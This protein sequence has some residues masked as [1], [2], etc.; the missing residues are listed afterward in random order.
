MCIVYLINN[1][2]QYFVDGMWEAW[3][4]DKETSK[5][6]VENSSNPFDEKWRQE[7]RILYPRY[8]SD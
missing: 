8:L 1:T 7:Y 5:L 4:A 2:A 6:V 3:P